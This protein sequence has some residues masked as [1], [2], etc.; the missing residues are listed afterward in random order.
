M[1]LLT[2][3]LRCARSSKAARETLVRRYEYTAAVCLSQENEKLKEWRDREKIKMKK[4]N[5]AAP[6]VAFKDG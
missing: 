2:W 3:R 6:S 5:S 4:A 1:L